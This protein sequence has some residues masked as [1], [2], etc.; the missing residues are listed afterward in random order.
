MTAR[1][2]KCGILIT[3]LIVWRSNLAEKLMEPFE[4]AI[5]ICILEAFM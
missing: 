2:L 5:K 4:T 1:I 3:K